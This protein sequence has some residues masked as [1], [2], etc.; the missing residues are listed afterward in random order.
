MTNEHDPQLRKLQRVKI[1]LMREPRFAFW[2]GLMMTGQTMLDDDLPTA[3]TDGCDEIYGRKFV[4]EQN[5]KGVGFAVLHENWHKMERHLTVWQSL[6][7]IDPQ[8]ANAACDYRINLALVDL[9]PTEQTIAF[10]K[11]P[12]GKRFGL[13]DERFRGMD[14]LQ[15]FR[16]LHAEKQQRQQQQQQQQGQSSAGQPGDGEG[17]GNFDQHEWGKAKERTKEEQDKIDKLI[18]QAVRQGAAEHAKVNGKGGGAMDRLL[19]EILEPQVDWREQLAEFVRS[20]CAGRDTTTWRRPNRRFLPQDILM[21]SMQSE[22]IGHIVVGVD[23]SGSIT[24]KQISLMLAEVLGLA[25]QVKPEK[26]DLIYWDSSV[27]SHE[28]YNEDNLSMLATSTKPRGGGGTSPSCVKRYLEE[29]RIE[30]ECVIILTDG[31][32]GADW[33]DFGCPTLWVITTKSINAA[34]GQ[35]IHIKED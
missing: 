4:V 20:V 13:Y 2:R 7:H 19:G 12:D 25:E 33:A 29:K 26:V 21:P 1:T 23:T 30:P 10:P 16:I 8:L 11:T 24:G 15:I 6:F 32:V 31:F 22:R 27:A 5:E 9:D 17:S 34:T 35:T 28:E 14:V 18:D 3:M